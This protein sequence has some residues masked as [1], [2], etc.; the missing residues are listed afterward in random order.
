VRRR[1]GYYFTKPT[2]LLLAMQLREALDRHATCW[3]AFLDKSSRD[4]RAEARVP[5]PEVSGHPSVAE[6]RDRPFTVE[7]QACDDEELVDALSPGVWIE[8]LGW[9]G[10][11]VDATFGLVRA[12]SG[13]GPTETAG[14]FWILHQGKHVRAQVRAPT[15]GDLWVYMRRRSYARRNGRAG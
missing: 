10:E 9:P 15:G 4:V 5:V 3:H 1:A 12:V 8:F 7:P 11:V 14:E 6:F 2:H 13:L